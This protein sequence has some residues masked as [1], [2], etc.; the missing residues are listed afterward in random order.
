MGN[1]DDKVVD[2]A[3]VEQVLARFAVS[4]TIAETGLASLRFR[5]QRSIVC[6][7]R[8][9]VGISSEQLVHWMGGSP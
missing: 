3:Q 8:E 5:A 4:P 7:R 9:E 6:V 1:I 2:S